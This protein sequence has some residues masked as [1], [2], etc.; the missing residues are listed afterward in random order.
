MGS[1]W[2]LFVFGSKYV[3]VRI[4]GDSILDVSVNVNVNVKQQ[5]RTSSLQNAVSLQIHHQA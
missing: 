2:V 3:H 1:L 5:K 4:F